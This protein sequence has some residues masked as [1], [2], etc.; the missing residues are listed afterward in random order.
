MAIQLQRPQKMTIRYKTIVTYRDDGNNERYSTILNCTYTD[1]DNDSKGCN[2]NAD[3]D[4]ARL[5]STKTNASW[6]LGCTLTR[7]PLLAKSIMQNYQQQ[8]L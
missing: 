2:R 6:H 4:N 8:I 5:K 3:R 7:Y 1:P